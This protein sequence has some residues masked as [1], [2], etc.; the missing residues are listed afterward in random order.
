VSSRLRPCPSAFPYRRPALSSGRQ[1][2][3]L[4]SKRG[5]RGSWSPR[6]ARGGGLGRANTTH[7]E[8]AVVVA[9]RLA[10]PSRKKRRM[11]ASRPFCC[12]LPLTSA[13][14]KPRP[15]TPAFACRVER[16]EPP[17]F[18]PLSQAPVSASPAAP[19]S[20]APPPRCVVSGGPRSGSSSSSSQ[21]P[22]SFRFSP[23]HLPVRRVR[24]SRWVSPCLA[25]LAG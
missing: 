5:L 19:T 24:T 14:L 4:S 6:M 22:S 8:A 21:C 13:R 18:P 23:S 17:H 15:L 25:S 10:A 12:T 2:F 7:D 9:T 3:L 20:A 16:S 11:F 1:S